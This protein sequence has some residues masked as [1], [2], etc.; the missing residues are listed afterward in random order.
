MPSPK[1]DKAAFRSR[2]LDR[3][4]D[5]AFRPL[6]DALERIVEVAWDAYREG[7]KSPITRKAG[8]EFADPNYD[9]SVDWLHAR[10]AIRAAQQAHD[11][12]EQGRRILLINGSPRSEHTC[13]GEMSKSWRLIEIARHAIA[14]AGCAVEVLDLS[15]LA[16]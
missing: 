3:F 11:A 14:R 12:E 6:D 10:A 16:S 7:R 9:L 1:L 15:R 2:F 13:P 8:P 4:H 5:P